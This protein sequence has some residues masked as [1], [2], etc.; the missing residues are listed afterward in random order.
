VLA[1]EDGGIRLENQTYTPLHYRVRTPTG[2]YADWRALLPGKTDDYSEFPRL[3]IE[4]WYSA[5]RSEEYELT[6]GTCAYYR[7]EPRGA[8]LFRA[9]ERSR[10]KVLPPG[11]PAAGS[12]PFGPLESFVAQCREHKQPYRLSLK[13]LAADCAVVPKGSPLPTELRYLRGFTWFVGYLI[14]DANDDVILLGVKDPARPPLDIDCLVKAVNCA[15]SGSEPRCSLDDDPEPGY[16]KSVVEGVPWTTRWAEVMIFADYDMGLCLRARDPHIPGFKIWG[17][18]FDEVLATVGWEG[19]GQPTKVVDGIKW[20]ENRWWFNL[21]STCPRA[22]ADSAGK[23][24][25]LYK[26]PMR[27]S[28]E[29]KVDG[30]YGSGKTTES[31]RRFARDFTE[32]M[33]R[34][35]QHY[36]NIAELQALF[37]LYDLMRHLREVSQT[38]VPIMPYW[39]QQ[40]VNAYDGPPRK[41]PRP[42]FVAGAQFLGSETLPGY[43]KLRLFFD[44]SGSAAM[45]ERRRHQPRQLAA[46][47]QRDH[48]AL[49]QQHRDL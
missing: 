10:P 31:A 34:L 43:G 40:Y 20:V 1:V 47:R 14:D 22:V 27:I 11:P 4:L 3:V 33:E 6:G 5:E 49:L 13:K 28:T 48:V 12:A 46:Q 36:P 38:V 9:C 18:H 15:S 26:N 16:Q 8:A 37:R 44:R 39:V 35:G 25:Y 17:Q 30:A 7:A 42:V 24:V 45:V 2:T 21:D 23:L 32:H 19:E 29:Q 41:M